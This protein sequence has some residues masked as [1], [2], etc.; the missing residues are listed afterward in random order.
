MFASQ[1]TR[2]A[3]RFRHSRRGSRYGSVTADGGRV[4]VPS[5]LTGVALP[6]AGR[7]TVPSQLT[8]ALLRLR[9]A[10]DSGGAAAG[11]GLPRAV[12]RQRPRALRGGGAGLRGT[13]GRVLNDAAVRGGVALRLRPGQR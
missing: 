11:G 4:T 1:P 12:V 7:V 5:Q 8:R 6:D 3:L 9:H 10:G 2:V 13:G